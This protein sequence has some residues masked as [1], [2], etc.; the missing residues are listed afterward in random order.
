M[1]YHLAESGLLPVWQVASFTTSFALSGAF[2]PKTGGGAGIAV[3][4]L[5]SAQMAN[6]QYQGVQT[7][8]SRKGNTAT[9]TLQVREAMQASPFRGTL[10]SRA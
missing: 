8:I 6:L 5:N 3:S 7:S 10:A 1:S 9:I 2:P 4:G